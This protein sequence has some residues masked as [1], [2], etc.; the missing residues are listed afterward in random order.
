[1]ET[2]TLKR[3][4]GV[5]LTS[6][7]L[8]FFVHHSR[9]IAATKTVFSD[10]KFL[11]Y[12]CFPWKFHLILVSH[13]E[14]MTCFSEDLKN[15]FESW[16]FEIFRISFFFFKWC[17][18]IFK[19][20]FDYILKVKKLVAS[21]QTRFSLKIVLAPVFL[22]LLSSKL[23]QFV[24]HLSFHLFIFSHIPNYSIYL[25]RTQSSI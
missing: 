6:P 1:M 15:D 22:L 5:K 18:C 11:S 12:L 25:F 13:S 19:L 7:P 16:M 20:Y 23:R 4:G 21:L 14:I 2:L 17:I 8:R 10:F 3:L 9:R 24:Q